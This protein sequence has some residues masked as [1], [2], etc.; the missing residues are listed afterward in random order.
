MAGRE[1]PAATLLEDPERLLR[2]GRLPRGQ[3]FHKEVHGDHVA[4]GHQLAVNQD[5]GGE[6]DVSGNLADVFDQGE[7]GL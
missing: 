3:P 5:P 2:A 4:F 7:V 1:Q 6:H